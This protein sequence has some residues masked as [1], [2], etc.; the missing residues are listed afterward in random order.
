MSK[1]PVLHKIRGPDLVHNKICTNHIWKSLS[2]IH[3]HFLKRSLMG[4]SRL[5]INPAQLPR[6]ASK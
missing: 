1:K 4:K 6:A 3:A 5:L 2:A